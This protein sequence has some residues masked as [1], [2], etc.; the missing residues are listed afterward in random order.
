M[1]GSRQCRCATA[2]AAPRLDAAPPP[3]ACGGSAPGLHDFFVIFVFMS[4]AVGGVLFLPARPISKW[5]QAGRK[6]VWYADHTRGSS[7]PGTHS[8]HLQTGA[9]SCA[10]QSPPCIG[11][12]QEQ[13]K[14]MLGIIFFAGLAASSAAAAAPATRTPRLQWTRR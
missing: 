2:P 9:R 6:Q 4:A 1:T 5:T 11:Q 10:V 8:E 3:L 13:M 12:E 14:R 7:A